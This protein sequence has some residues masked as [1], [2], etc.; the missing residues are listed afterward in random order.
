M[1][2]K[3][4]KWWIA[5]LLSLIEPGLGQIYNGQARKGLIFLAIPLLLFPSMILCVNSN[6]ILFFLISFAL[7]TV[8]YHIT[9]IADAIYTGHKLKTDYTL[10][11]FNKVIVYIGVIALVFAVNTIIPRYIKNNYVQAYKIPA[12]SNEP[13]LL[14]GDHILTDRSV[15]ARN[16]NRGDLIIF[17]F[18]KD[19]K[20]DFV[21]R[22]VATG[23]DVV[24]IQ[25][26]V[27]LINNMIIKEDY[28]IHTDSKVL[29]S[30]HVPRDNFGPVTVPENFFFVMGDN[31]DNSYDSRFWGFVEKSKVKGTVKNIYWSW[32]KERFNVR[33]NRI[34]TKVE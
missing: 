17:E 29:S 4:R 27:L 28:A 23:G 2:N 10:K 8:A 6:K 15:S 22:V 31:R 16:P 7:F 20:K 33:W 3:P 25:N 5:G 34:G 30:N 9:V 32:D 13:T 21:K 18:P 14:V 11:K 19:S 24:E 1:N 12:A 26:K